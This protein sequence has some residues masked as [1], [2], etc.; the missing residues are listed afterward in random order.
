MSLDTSVAEAVVR[1][2]A[3]MIEKEKMR[4]RE[5]TRKNEEARNNIVRFAD[6]S[7]GKGIF[8]FGI[9]ILHGL[10]IGTRLIWYCCS[11]DSSR[12]S[13]ILLDEANPFVIIQKIDYEAFRS[14][15]LQIS[16]HISED[17]FDMIDDVN[18]TIG[19]L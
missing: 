16:G 4:I 7:V 1:E 8:G 10:P 12:Q 15:A 17:I 18:R 13:T 19:V 2:K 3:K 14:R 6:N 9:D 11:D 5:T